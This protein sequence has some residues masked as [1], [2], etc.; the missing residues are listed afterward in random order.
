VVNDVVVDVVVVGAG[1]V[2]LLLA[3]E[4][5]LSGVTPLALERLTERSSGTE[6]ERTGGAVVR[7]LDHRGLYTRLTGDTRPPLPIPT[8]MRGPGGRCCW[9]SPASRWWRGSRRAGGTA[10]TW[11]GPPRT[12]HPRP[13]CWCGRTGTWLADAD[14]AVSLADALPTSLGES[15]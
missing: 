5:R 10:S 15:Q 6:G 11:S 7:F 13:R 4:L 12:S 1:P 3:G 9:T 14:L 8:Y 2:G